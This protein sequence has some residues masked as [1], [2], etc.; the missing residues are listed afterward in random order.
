[1]SHYKYRAFYRFDGPSRVDPFPTE[2]SAQE[3]TE[4]L[5]RFPLELE[6]YIDAEATVEVPHPQ[7]LAGFSYVTV[8]TDADKELIDDAVKRCVS[9]LQLYGDL[10]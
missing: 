8:V 1:M 5:S 10:L 7:P 2:K 9:S 4:A 3:V 6:H